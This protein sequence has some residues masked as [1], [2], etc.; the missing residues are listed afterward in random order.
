MGRTRAAV[1][2]RRPGATLAVMLV[3]AAAVGTM[4]SWGLGFPHSLAFAQASGQPRQDFKTS[5]AARIARAATQELEVPPAV[6]DLPADEELAKTGGFVQ[7][8][9]NRYKPTREIRWTT[10]Y[11]RR[12]MNEEAERL[13][14]Y[15]MPLLEKQ[16]SAKDIAFALNRIGHKIRHLLFRPPRGLPIFTESRVRKIL[17]KGKNDDG[18]R[19]NK[20]L[21]QDNLPPFAPGARY[22]T[23]MVASGTYFAEVPPLAPW[24]PKVAGAPGA[25]GAPWER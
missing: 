22:P 6:G 17:R 20:F 4:I 25:P 15:L 21:R 1:S 8:P 10:S 16:L 23:E 13:K 11:T 3:I 5:H 14:P 18:I 12:N 24:S 9:S 7:R 2:S 19:L